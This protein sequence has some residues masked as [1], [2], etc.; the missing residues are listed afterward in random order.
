MPASKP[1]LHE[2]TMQ[3]EI[4]ESTFQLSFTSFL[5][6]LLALVF[7]PTSI[8]LN[9]IQLPLLNYEDYKWHW[10]LRVGTSL[11]GIFTDARRYFG[12]WGDYEFIHTHYRP[13]G[14]ILI[15]T[16]AGRLKRALVEL[17]EGIDVGILREQITA[18]TY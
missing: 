6:K 13:P 2:I 9:D 17:D 15:E 18:A 1:Q 4:T 14:N 10:G 7:L 8:P 11:P 16:K 12:F 5:D 3:I